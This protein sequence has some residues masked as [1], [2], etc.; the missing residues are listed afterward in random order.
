MFQTHSEVPFDAR[1]PSAAA[2]AGVGWCRRAGR[3]AA[4]ALAGL[5]GTALLGG[6]AS[7]PA[8]AERTPSTAPANTSDTPLGKVLAP[9]LAKRPGESLFYPLQSG[10]DALAARLA[11]ARAAQRSLDLQT[12]I[13]EPTGTGAAVL[14]D[15]LDAADRGVRVRMLLDDLH[16]G[17][18]DKVLSAIDSHPNIE[19]RLFNPFANRSVRWLEM[20]VG[21][22]RLD[23][24]M[25]NKSMTVDNQIT[26][27]GGRNVGDA[28][29]SARTD[30][31]FSDLDVLVAGPAV[32][33]VSAVFDEYWNDASSYPVVA[34]IPA[35]KEAP[36]EMRGL[37]KRL[38]AR[39][40]QAVAS[41]YV[42][43]LLDSGL[44]RGI[45]SGHMPGYY[46]KA[47]V[48]SDKAAK[49]TH[50]THDDP[51]HA[52]AR[53]EKMISS[54]QKEVL[55]ISPYFVPDDD[56]EAWLI[57]L[58]RRGIRVRILT[59]SFAATDVSPV[60]AG[61]APHR[62][63]LVAAG[64]ELYELKPSAYAELANRGKAARGSRSRAWLSSS[65][66]S[67]HAKNYIVD[68]RLV[69]IGSL[70]MDP[71]SAK[72]N[73]EMGVVLDSPALAERMTRST[74]DG[75]LDMAYRVGLQ[76]DGDGGNPR[77]T[78]TT[79]EKGQLVVYDSEPGMGPL[80]HLGIG[81]L[82]VLPIKEEL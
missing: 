18:L 57:A 49:I 43:E 54:A 15:I 72:L 35:G 79:R 1:L 77:L 8:Q 14:G 53:L 47:V 4:I 80:Q 64:V 3:L 50:Q 55:L 66:A 51:G 27:L 40:D 75:L 42:Q 46:G 68:R 59:N 45:E 9:R 73:T 11:M 30:M 61:Y 70:N 37:R 6:C 17:G 36:V 12:Y 33:Q 67:L 81:V 16:T 44:A 71:R 25:H 13:F 28:Y 52:T 56:G 76:T 26:L 32:P 60:H 21:F 63:A 41:P 10:P 58:A 5:V 78:W 23:R 20:L 31:D 34:L 19:V 2:R 48:V 74:E 62:R 82:R 39:G 38:E 24:R 69:F 7:L 65:R 22:K 29:F